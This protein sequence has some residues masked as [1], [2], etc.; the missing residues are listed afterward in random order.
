MPPSAFAKEQA[1]TQA[2]ALADAPSEA[3][4]VIALDK[5][6]QP[7]TD[8]KPEEVRIFEDKAE[9]KI[10]SVLLVAD[11]PLTVGLFF[12]VSGS[13]H[14]DRHVNEEVKLT[15]EFVHSVWHEGDTGFV[16]AFSS[17]A[18][19]A[20]QP[21]HKLEEVDDGLSKIPDAT[22]YGSTALYDALC[23][24]KADKLNLTR[25]RKVYVAF[26]DFEDNSSRNKLENVVELA[27]AAKIAVF[28]VIL[29]QG[30]GGGYSKRAEKR[31]R[32]TAQEIADKTGGEVLIPESHK[33]LKPIFERLAAEVRS[34]YRISYSPSS[35]PGDH[36]KKKLHIEMTRPHSKVLFAKD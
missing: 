22:Y 35:L 31:G 15:T 34:T 14:D 19:V 12:D 20:T 18:F 9:Q 29:S 17:G 8:L 36:R 16:L 5:D 23:I 28:P 3:I 2:P 25:G 30:F 24:L 13:R 4:Y 32:Q 1:V 33:E 6:G 10:T 7:I 21:T 27:H 11:E 26:S